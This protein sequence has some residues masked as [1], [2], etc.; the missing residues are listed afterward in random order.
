MV[1][2]TY[3]NMR[4]EGKSWAVPSPDSY[5]LESYD[6]DDDANKVSNR[7]ARGHKYPDETTMAS[8]GGTR[9]GILTT[10]AVGVDEEEGRRRR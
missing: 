1:F 9:L 5:F 2:V 10:A 4:A 3:Q 6:E 7:K 8:G